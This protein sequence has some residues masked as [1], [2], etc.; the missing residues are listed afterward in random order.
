MP[1]AH[2]HRGREKAARRNLTEQTL[3]HLPAIL[4]HTR[5]AQKMVIRHEPGQ[6]S[7]ELHS[8]RRHAEEML[9]DARSRL[10]NLCLVG[11]TATGVAVLPVFIERAA[12]VGANVSFVSHLVITLTGLVGAVLRNRLSLHL[13]AGLVIGL[14]LASAFSSFL[15]YGI[16]GGGFICMDVFASVVAALVMGWRTG[17]AVLTFSSAG[18]VVLSLAMLYGPLEPATNLH[19]YL[20]QKVSWF[21]ALS[22]W[23]PPAALLVIGIEQM[24]AIL[25]E[26]IAGKTQSHLLLEEKNR[27]LESLFRGTDSF[28]LVTDP[29]LRITECNAACLRSTQRRREDVL[30]QRLGDVF[31]GEEEQEALQAGFADGASANHENEWRGAEGRR[32]V[33][34]WNRNPITDHWGNLTHWL[35]SGIDVSDR[36]VLQKKMARSEK[37]QALGQLAGGVAHDFNNMLTGILGAAELLSL[38]AEGEQRSRYLKLI[39][40]SGQ[41]AAGLTQKLLAFSRAESRPNEVLDINALIVEAGKLIEMGFTNDIRLILDPSPTPILLRGDASQLLNAVLNLGLNARDAM[42]EGG[43]LTISTRAEQVDSPFVLEAGEELPPGPYAEIMVS[44]TGHG[45][46]REHLARI[47]EPFFT[48]K[49]RDRGTGLGLASVH[50][51]VRQHGGAVWVYS[52]VGRGTQFRVLLPREAGAQE[53]EQPRRWVTADTGLLRILVVDDDDAIR[54]A[55]ADF[56]VLLGHTVEVAEDGRVAL[57][58]LGKATFDIVI[59]DWLMPRLDGRA[60]LLAIR[61]RHPDLPVLIVSGF[62]PD[63]DWLHAELERGASEFLRKPYQQGELLRHVA[64]LCAQAKEQQQQA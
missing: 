17:I 52:E 59:L 3:S 16:V 53:A 13:R 35:I 10:V 30:G 40:T 22:A 29:E 2:L 42:R 63:R 49:G 11:L 24:H 21:A 44:D 61:E 57:E 26:F 31:F 55:T 28:F 47:F 20:D 5:C 25:R 62:I 37:M 38:G 50:G 46:E 60:T 18:F 32:L 36:N 23:L 27:F 4:L 15:S 54:E 56:L 9:H 14:A 6:V 8:D 45:I 19:A 58:H 33:V 39:T 12:K 41:R 43:T 64:Q 1:W 34:N 7:Q 48:T 51:T